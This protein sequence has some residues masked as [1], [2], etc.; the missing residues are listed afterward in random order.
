MR[1]HQIFHHQHLFSFRNLTPRQGKH[2]RV[3]VFYPLTRLV[4]GSVQGIILLVML[5]FQL[6][7]RSFAAPLYL[8][9]SNDAILRVSTVRNVLPT[10]AGCRHALS[11]CARGY[12]CAPSP[13]APA[14]RGQPV[15]Q[16]RAGFDNPHNSRHSCE[17]Q[18]HSVQEYAAPAPA[19]HGHGRPPVHR[20]DNGQAGRRTMS[21]LAGPWLVGSSS[22]R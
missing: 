14:P 3:I 9:R 7:I 16:H 22:S 13:R 18:R 19:T 21:G 15:A 10:A 6:P 5:F 4:Y 1:Q 17:D 11:A 8:T 20:P 2:H 12:V